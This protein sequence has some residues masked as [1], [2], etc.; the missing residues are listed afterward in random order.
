MILSCFH[1]DA[2]LGKYGPSAMG[3]MRLGGLL[4]I[5]VVGIPLLV[6]WRR[7]RRGEYGTPEAHA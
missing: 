7:E 2:E 6:V 3:L 1:Y 4:M 5:F